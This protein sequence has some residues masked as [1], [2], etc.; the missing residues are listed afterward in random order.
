MRRDGNN[1]AD[2]AGAEPIEASP[3]KTPLRR[4]P[5]RRQRVSRRRHRRLGGRARGVHAAPRAAS[6][7][8]RHG[9][10]AHPAPRS[11][12]TRAS[13]PRRWPRRRRWRSPR[14]TDGDAGG[15]RTTSTSSRRTRTSASQGV[16]HAPAAHAREPQAPPAIDFF[17][18]PSPQS[19]AATPSAWCSRARP[20]TAPKA[21]GPSRRRAASRSRRTR[22]RRSSTRCRAARSRPASSTIALPIPEL[23]AELVRLSQHPYVA[24]RTRRSRRPRDDGDARARSSP[25]C[26]AP[27]GW[28]SREYKRA[29]FERRLA[30]RMALR[31]VE[32]SAGLPALLERGARGGPRPLRGRPHPRHLVL[33]RPGGVRGAE[34]AG[35]PRASSSRR[36]RGRH[37][38]L[39]GRMLHGRGGLLARHPLLE[40][41][42]RR[43]RTPIQIFGSDVSEQAIEQARAGLYPDSALRDVGEERRKRYFTRSSAGTESAR[44]CAICASSSGTTWPATRRSPSWIW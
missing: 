9:V 1:P 18:A 23:A 14:P 33:P 36:P 13:S 6:R 31:R 20:R 11:R 3:P 38:H 39:G 26:A 17:F 21:C 42:A 10:R 12:R 28:T 2:S 16:A 4:T 30:R 25:S 43:A 22:G 8:Q 29:T 35:L 32:R 7:R 15:A 44:R 40:I 5:T 41:L 19:A 24:A 27:S 34:G 37:P